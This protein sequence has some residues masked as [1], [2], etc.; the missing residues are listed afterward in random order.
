MSRDFIF[1]LYR[2]NIRQESG[3]GSPA[4]PFE[5][6]RTVQSDDD[7]VQILSHAC[8]PNFARP[9]A[10][11][12]GTYTWSL[13]NFAELATQDEDSGQ[14][15]AFQITRSTV[16]KVGFTPTEDGR[17][18]VGVSDILPPQSVMAQAIFR[19]DKHLVAIEVFSEFMQSGKWL[20]MLHGILA[21]AA[22]D[23]HFLSRLQF[24]VKPSRSE[25]EASFRSFDKLT[26]LQVTLWLPNPEVP[27]D[28][29]A[30]Y[31]ELVNGGIRRFRQDMSN[32]NGLNRDPGNLPHSAISIAQAGYKEGELVLEG[33]TDGEVQE[34]RTGT[35]PSRGEVHQVRDIVRGMHMGAT[36]PN[37]KRTLKA[38]LREI[39]RINRDEPAS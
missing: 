2:M 27:D 20:E 10:V 16:Q 28:A 34:I 30:F 17:T 19:L 8:H 9:D 22:E 25:I 31:D 15:L 39:D 32:P 11:P 5:E 24:E 23:L 1:D 14:V 33:E 3:A 6:R 13:T 38:L 4:L 7:I 26:R 12:S 29:K 36:D 18:V 37:V 21:A 35:N